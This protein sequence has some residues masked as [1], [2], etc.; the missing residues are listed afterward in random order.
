MARRRK[1]DARPNFNAAGW[2]DRIDLILFVLVF[3]GALA[4]TFLPR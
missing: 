3:C 2:A 1:R 4:L